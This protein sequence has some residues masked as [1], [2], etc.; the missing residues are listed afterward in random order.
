MSKGP[1][2][3]KIRCQTRNSNWKQHLLKLLTL[4]FFF[5][6]W[7][8]IKLNIGIQQQNSWARSILIYSVYYTLCRAIVHWG[9]RSPHMPQRL[10]LDWSCGDIWP[11]RMEVGVLRTGHLQPDEYQRKSQVRSGYGGGH[12]AALPRLTT[13]FWKIPSSM[14]AGEGLGFHSVSIVDN[15]TTYMPFFG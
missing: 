9:H 8:K 11:R 5:I 15:A 7:L 12:S 3:L 13:H 10:H 6:F 1:Q 2:W 4:F 14:S